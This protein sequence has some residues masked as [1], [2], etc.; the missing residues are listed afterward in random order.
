MAN[1]ME[2]AGSTEPPN[3]TKS[4]GICRRDR[5]W[6]DGT[7]GVGVPAHVLLGRI[8]SLISILMSSL[9]LTVPET[10][11]FGREVFK[12][13]IKTLVDGVAYDDTYVMNTQSGTQ[14]D[15]FRHVSQSCVKTTFL[16]Y[17][18]LTHSSGWPHRRQVLLQ[19]GTFQGYQHPVPKTNPRRP[20]APIL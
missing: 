20:K 5:H 16:L 8:W 19:W 2:L 6:R 3:S 15:G 9:P 10:P 12:H 1:T 11:A 18:T 13:E 7:L 17:Q 14:W 4:Q